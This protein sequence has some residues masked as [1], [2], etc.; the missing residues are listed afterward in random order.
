VRFYLAG[1]SSE[2]D[3]VSQWMDR[4]RELGHIV[5]FD[6]P[7]NIRAVG[8]ANP[9]DAT[10]DQR[11]AWALDNVRGI[12]LADVFWLLIPDSAAASIG[13]WVEYGIAQ[14]LG[15][16]HVVVSGDWTSTIFTSLADQRFDSHADAIAWLKSTDRDTLF[17][18]PWRGTPA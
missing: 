17:P 1:A 6:W 15:V 18:G 16:R 4:V 13:C 9:R 11:S 5:T 2:M 10:E 12:R 3:L 7:A 14:E 8:A